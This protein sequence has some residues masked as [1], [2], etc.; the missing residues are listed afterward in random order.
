MRQC[1]IGPLLFLFFFKNLLNI[2]KWRHV[3]ERIE[4]KKKGNFEKGIVSDVLAAV[5]FLVK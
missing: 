2:N 5:M 3:G 4:G 1:I